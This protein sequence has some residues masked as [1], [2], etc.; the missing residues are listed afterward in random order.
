MHQRRRADHTAGYSGIRPEGKRY[1]FFGKT[2]HQWNEARGVG[3]MLAEKAVDFFAMDIKT[4]PSRYEEIIGAD[5][6]VD[7]VKKIKRDNPKLRT[8]LRI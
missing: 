5:F 4:G 6:S 2:G 8:A 3:K 1:G 7:E